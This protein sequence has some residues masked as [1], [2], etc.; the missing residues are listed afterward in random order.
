MKVSIVTISYNQ[1]RY[2]E[3]AICSVLEQDYP[4]IEYIVVDAGSTDGS[5]EIIEKYRDQ[6]DQIIFE[7]DDGPADGLNKGFQH[8]NGDIFGYLNSDD[9]LLPN[10]VSQIAQAF[11]KN[12]DASVISGHGAI[13]DADGRIRKQVY[14]HRFNLNA[15]AYGVCVLVQQ[16]SFFR[17]DDFFRVG[18]FNPFNRVSW[19][20]ELWADMALSGAKF[21][22]L[23]SYLA[24]FRVHGKSITGSGEYRMEIQ[25][26]HARIC[27]K[28][29]I[30]PKSNL[31]R[32]IIWSLNRL[33]DPITTTARF[34]DG[35]K[36][37]FSA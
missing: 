8:A 27:Q 34:L 23:H 9:I 5:R 21:S 7:S 14:S 20:G 11:H 32:K 15:Y 22:R 37:G 2:L 12:S 6:I 30:F 19:D 33:S 1:V 25:K 16:A 24:N 28:I 10:A 18:C 4:N 31:K 13:I 17:K 3:Q 36:N 26:Q 35:V 29:G